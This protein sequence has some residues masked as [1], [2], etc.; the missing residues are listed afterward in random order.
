MFAVEQYPDEGR[1]WPL[2]FTDPSRGKWLVDLE[3]GLYFV[4]LYRI[5]RSEDMR[6]LIGDGCIAIPL[7]TEFVYWESH[8]DPATGQSYKLTRFRFFGNRPSPAMKLRNG[9][10]WGW[11]L[12]HTF[13]NDADRE[14]WLRA[15]AEAVLVY[16]MAGTGLYSPEGAYRVDVNGEHL[17][18]SDFGYT[19]G[20]TSP[21]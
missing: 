8:T 11:F 20:A 6:C 15:A 18:L 16:G 7:A 17:R 4:L 14:Y 3:R 1:P 21:A 19:A 13:A 9:K 2:Q 12:P 5:T 10:H